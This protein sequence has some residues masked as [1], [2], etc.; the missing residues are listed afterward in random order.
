MTRSDADRDNLVSEL[1]LDAGVP[2]DALL[3]A[4]LESIAGLSALPAPAP[5]GDLAALLGVPS[6]DPDGGTDP[7]ADEL[8]KRRRRKHRPVVIAGAVLTAMG[9]GIGGVAASGGLQQDSPDFFNKLI[10]GWA[11]HTNL[12]PQSLLPAG[13]APDA[14]KVTAVPAPSSPPVSEAAAGAQGAASPS[15]VPNHP[16][17]S[18]F[19]GKPLAAAK[20]AAKARP[21]K[22]ANT[23][24]GTPPSGSTGS[25]SGVPAGPSGVNFKDSFEGVLDER[26]LVGGRTVEDVLDQIVR[27]G[28]R[29]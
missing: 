14:P 20:K 2:G 15:A 25:A 13:P 19:K 26:G 7:G 12:A 29:L 23:L 3:K 27:L 9:L 24:K 6:A 10:A 5:R 17:A 28:V 22:A 11:P 16:P 1:M 8:A 4:A 18:A 21:K